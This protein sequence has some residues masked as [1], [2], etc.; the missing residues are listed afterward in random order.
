[1]Q[2]DWHG[3]PSFCGT[4]NHKWPSL[5]FPPMRSYKLTH[6]PKSKI[7]PNQSRLAQFWLVLAN[8][9]PFFWGANLNQIC[10]NGP[11]FTQDCNELVFWHPKHEIQKIPDRR[12][13]WDKEIKD[14]SQHPQGQPKMQELILPWLCHGRVVSPFHLPV[15][16]RPSPLAPLVSLSLQ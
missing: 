6:S 3:F 16:G 10:Q 14:Q 7:G 15:S 13:S 5:G 9:S 4:N 8:L 11:R 2:I 12:L 1:M